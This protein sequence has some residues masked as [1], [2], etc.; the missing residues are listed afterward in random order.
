MV[1]YLHRISGSAL[2]GL[3]VLPLIAFTSMKWITPRFAKKLGAIGCLG[4]A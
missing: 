3:Y 4:L 1:E 2:G